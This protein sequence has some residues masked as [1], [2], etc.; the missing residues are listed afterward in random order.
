MTEPELSVILCTYNRGEKLGNV[1]NDF[2]NQVFPEGRFPWE[3][4]LVDNN[5]N[6]GTKELVQEYKKD[7]KFPIRYIFE[8]QQGKSFALNTGIE[9]AAGNLLAFTDDDVI[10]DTQ[11]LSSIYKAFG[12]YP[13]NN[14]FGGKV[15][16]VIE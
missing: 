11:W 13:N 10:L 2:A 4:V 6:D 15:L 7:R 5:S 12:S 1:L 3:L 8:S 14:C 16:P 9:T